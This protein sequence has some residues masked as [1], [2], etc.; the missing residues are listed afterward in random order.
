MEVV[1]RN[2]IIQVVILIFLT[3]TL[4]SLLGVF[5]WTPEN[6]EAPPVLIDTWGK[7]GVAPGEF[8]GPIGIT[9]KAGL[10]VISDP[11]NSRLQVFDERGKLIRIIEHEKMVRPMHISLSNDNIYVSEYQ[12]DMILIFNFAGELLQ[13]VGKSGNGPGEF[14][15]PAGV[16]VD[17]QGNIYVADFYNHRIQILDESGRFLRQIGKT[18][19]KGFLPGKFNYPTDLAITHDQKI[20]VADAY[21]DRVQVFSQ[22]GDLIDWWGGP[23]GL[24][25]AGS[26]NGWFKTAT[27]IGLGNKDEVFVADFYNN[28]VQKLTIE[29]DFLVAITGPE[30]AFL[31]RPTDIFLSSSGNLYVVDFGNHQIKV[32]QTQD[33]KNITED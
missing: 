1:F 9:G 6:R 5:L 22:N 30:N 3:T 23:F 2:K 28:R 33:L 24:N 25:I 17:H 31:S 15:A 27:G 29:G 4:I 10:I 7:E 8:K 16:A 13:T 21:N 26:F 20:V 32:F 18:K 11:G 14:D 19:E 12:N